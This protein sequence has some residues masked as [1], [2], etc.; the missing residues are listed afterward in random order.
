MSSAAA[1]L[2]PAREPTPFPRESKARA[3]AR[4]K[5]FCRGTKKLYLRGVT[6]GTFR[7]DA[8]GHQYGTPA[9]VRRDFRMMAANNVNYVRTYT[10]PPR[11]LLDLALEHGLDVMVGLP[12]EQ[13]ITFLDDRRRTAA[14]VTRVREQARALA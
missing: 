13:H 11:W 10:A 3:Q 5:F 1:E 2:F 14:V 8:E 12:W 7:P 6:Y 4:G 9:S